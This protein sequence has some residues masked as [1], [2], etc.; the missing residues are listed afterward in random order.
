[1]SS[2]QWAVSI[3]QLDA[4]LMRVNSRAQPNMR[5]KIN[6]RHAP[7]ILRADFTRRWCLA[8]NGT[9]NNAVRCGAA[10]SGGAVRCG[11]VR[12]GAVRCG[13]VPVHTESQRNEMP[14]S[15]WHS[16][17]LSAV[18]GCIRSACC[19]GAVAREPSHSAASTEHPRRLGVKRAQLS[20]IGIVTDV[21]SIV[22]RH[23]R[24]AADH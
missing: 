13:A 19:R 10:R 22:R 21:A 12:C 2:G 15:A 18:S 3:E 7:W 17:T 20:G 24:S 4:L 1:V 14:Y 16:V 5:W 6:W 8:T 9:T 11:V 23:G